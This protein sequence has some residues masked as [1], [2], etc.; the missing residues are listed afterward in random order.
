ML[1]WDRTLCG[2]LRLFVSEFFM[3][4]LRSP[5]A[6]LG[7]PP[8]TMLVIQRAQAAPGWVCEKTCRLVF[9]SSVIYGAYVCFST[10]TSARTGK[11]CEVFVA[12]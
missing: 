3:R 8:Q 11:F 6:C 10:G 7:R 12:E 2:V 5:L 1:D 4:S 9:A